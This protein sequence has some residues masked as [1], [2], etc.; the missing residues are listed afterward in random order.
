MSDYLKP[1]IGDIVVIK[2]NG[3]VKLAGDLLEKGDVTGEVIE[4][5]PKGMLI[6]LDIHHHVFVY[7]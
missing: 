5:S 7:T 4:V 3:W 6:K 2:K 1:E